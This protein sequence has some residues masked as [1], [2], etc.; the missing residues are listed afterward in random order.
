MFKVIQY[1]LQVTNHII[2]RTSII[3]YMVVLD[4][5]VTLKND[6]ETGTTNSCAT[7]RYIS[8]GA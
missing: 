3:A 5:Y 7:T 6:E 4:P 2:S 8:R 1:H